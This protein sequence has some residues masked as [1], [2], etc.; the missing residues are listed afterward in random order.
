MRIAGNIPLLPLIGA[1]IGLAMAPGSAQV[2]PWK[3]ACIA[4][5][6][7]IACKAENRTVIEEAMASCRTAADK[8]VCHKSYLRQ[9]RERPKGPPAVIRG[10]RVN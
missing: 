6:P 4:I 2:L 8:P 3:E 9:L 1:A 5:E 7:T 10:S